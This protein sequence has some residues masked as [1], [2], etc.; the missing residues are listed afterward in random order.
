MDEPLFRSSTKKAL[1]ELATELNLR[2]KIP[3]WDSMAGLSYTPGNPEDIQEYLTYYAQLKED[4]K[5]FT[6]MEMILDSMAHQPNEREFMNYWRKVKPILIKD[7]VIHE[8]TIQYW[9]D[10]TVQNFERSDIMS[11]LIRDVI[12]VLKSNGK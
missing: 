7:Y 5:K 9:K 3:H 12:S 4:D 6:L 1:D 10:M 8:F 2:E 11:P